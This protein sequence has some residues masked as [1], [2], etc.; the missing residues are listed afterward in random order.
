MLPEALWCLL[1]A[2]LTAA[3]AS[4]TLSLNSNSAFS[5][6][7]T[8]NPPQFILPNA[9]ILT[10]SVALCSSTTS[11]PRF[12]V[13]NSS[14]TVTPTSNGGTDVF[15]IQ[16][17]QG[18]GIW[19]GIFTH[20]GLLA[21]EGLGEV[22]FQ[23]GVSDEDPIHEILPSSDLPLLGD[24]TSNQALIFSPAFSE[25]D[26][27]IPTF[28][29]YTFPPANQSQP[30]LPSSSPNFTLILSPTSSS[31]SL[32]SLPQTGCM[33]GSRNSTGV[34]ANESL[35]LPNS[36]GWRTQWLVEGLT[37]S[38]NY[39]AYVIQNGTKVGGPIYFATKSGMLFSAYHIVPTLHT[40][41]HF[42][43]R[44]QQAVHP[45]IRPITFLIK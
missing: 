43:N 13:T 23:L 26:V 12:F 41:F 19:S 35:W 44:P 28:P 21:I 38:T 2:A 4:A 33:L 30:S 10:I 20:G 34:I 40:L 16:L 9:P 14:T 6:S 7:N 22:S 32:T 3:Q 42:P 39:T 29:N 11:V 24:T 25:V 31:P 1:S 37:P 5:Q 27:Y 8:P 18:L 36:N 15:E 17:T 45:S